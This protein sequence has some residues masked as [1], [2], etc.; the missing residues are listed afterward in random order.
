MEYKLDRIS[1]RPDTA[2]RLCERDNIAVEIIQN[3]TLWAVGLQ[4]AKYMY[5]WSLQRRK[6]TE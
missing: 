1:S 3:K 5:N 4:S 6:V 2:E